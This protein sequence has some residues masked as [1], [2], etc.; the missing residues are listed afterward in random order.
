MALPAGS[1]KIKTFCVACGLKESITFG[2]SQL[3]VLA[4]QVKET[5]N[6]KVDIKGEVSSGKTLD[7]LQETGMGFG[8]LSGALHEIIASLIAYIAGKNVEKHKPETF[9]S[10]AREGAVKCNIKAVHDG[11]LFFHKVGLLFVQKFLFIPRSEVKSIDFTGTTGRTFDV[12][13]QTKAGEK[14][15]FSM[16]A[17]EEHQR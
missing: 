15:D 16:I 4:L 14:H 12:Q 6:G 8:V 3:K 7:G 5:E 11:F 10:V 1:Q 13:V 2:K 9:L 17:K